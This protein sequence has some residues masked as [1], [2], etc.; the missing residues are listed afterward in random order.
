MERLGCVS[1]CWPYQDG[2]INTQVVRVDRMIYP[3]KK[4]H[5]ELFGYPAFLDNSKC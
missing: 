4:C 1:I 5:S 2:K 3:M